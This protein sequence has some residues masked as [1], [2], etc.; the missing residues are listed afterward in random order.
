[1]F[2]LQWQIAVLW[3]HKYMLRQF[4]MS[5]ARKRDM[6]GLAWTSTRLE[7]HGVAWPQSIWMD[8]FL[9][10]TEEVLLGLGLFGDG[11]LNIL[12]PRLSSLLRNFMS[13]LS[14]III[15]LPLF[16]IW[17][18]PFLHG[19]LEIRK[20]K[21]CAPGGQLKVYINKVC[22]RVQRIIVILSL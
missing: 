1:M 14:F 18:L 11:S 5:E 7:F 4:P 21:L 20:E 13:L 10:I 15:F 6:S 8:F 17:K 22:R 2:L 9:P 16:K 3:K 19:K 12:W